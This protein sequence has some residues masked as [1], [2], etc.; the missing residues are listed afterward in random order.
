MV[1]YN[2]DAWGNFVAEKVR[3]VSIGNVV[4]M[5]GARFSS[6]FALFLAGCKKIF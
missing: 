3:E 4:I 6:E 2:Y 5:L 1:E